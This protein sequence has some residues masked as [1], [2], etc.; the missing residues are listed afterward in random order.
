[1]HACPFAKLSYPQS[2]LALRALDINF[3]PCLSP[4]PQRMEDTNPA[5]REA[6]FE[7]VGTLLKVAGDRPM[8]VFLDGVDKAKMG[9][10]GVARREEGVVIGGRWAW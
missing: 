4:P 8:N 10:V 7:T 2:I 3:T 6:S 5:V 1:M 9:K